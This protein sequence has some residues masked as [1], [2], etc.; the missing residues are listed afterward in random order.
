MYIHLCIYICVYIYICIH[1]YSLH[2]CIHIYVARMSTGIEQ[3]VTKV[4]CAQMLCFGED[5]ACKRR[6]A[7]TQLEP[8]TAKSQHRGQRV[9]CFGSM[10][11]RLHS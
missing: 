5:T 9:V 11:V 3:T 7:V 1:I 2:L 6:H 4:C 8:V 10:R